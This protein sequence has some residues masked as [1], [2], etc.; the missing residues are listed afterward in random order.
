ME[1]DIDKETE[2]YDGVGEKGFVLIPTL[3]H[4]KVKDN[5]EYYLEKAGLIEKTTET[6][7][8]PRGT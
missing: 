2:L 3:T 7:S 4:R 1:L 6:L 5:L 8:P